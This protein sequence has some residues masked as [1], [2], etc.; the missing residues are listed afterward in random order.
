MLRPGVISCS[1]ALN[2]I[3]FKIRALLISFL[4]GIPFSHS[5][6]AQTNNPTLSIS[7]SNGISTVYWPLTSYFDILQTATTLSPSATWTNLATGEQI[8]SLKTF[9]PLTIGGYATYASNIV[10]DKITF[11]LSSPDTQRFFRLRTPLLIPACCFAIFYDGLLEFSQSPP[12]IINGRVHANGGIFV[13]TSSTT[14][15]IF[16][17]AV[18]TTS[19]VTAPYMDGLTS[20]WIPGIPSTW[21]TTFDGN[22]GFITNVSSVTIWQYVTNYHFLIDVPPAG[23]DPTSSTGQVRYYNQ[24]QM[25]LIVTNAVSGGLNPTV[26]LKL[27]NSVNGQVPGYDPSPVILYYTNASPSLLS[28]NLPFL[29]LTNTAYDQ[30]E[31]ATNIFAQIDVDKFAH[32]I[33]TNAAVQGK[34]PSSAG[35]YPT[36]LYVADL[37][38]N[39]S[40]QLSS[41]RLVNGAQLPANN[42]LGLTLATMNPLYVQGHYNV[43]TASSAANASAGTNNTAYTV[44]SA[45]ISDALTVLSS[46]WSDAVSFTSTYSQGNANY[47]ATDNNTINAAIITGTMPSTGTNG[48]TFSGGFHNLPRLL[49]NWSS[50]NLWLNTSIIRLWNSQ[51]ATNQFRNPAGFSPLPVNPYYNPPTRHFNFDTN[52]L[53]DSKTPPGAPMFSA[54]L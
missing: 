35:V 45:L 10:G 15:L 50:K 2:D 21:N 38:S 39:T 8:L 11:S 16:N 9:P 30:R 23:E 33:Q 48:S 29:S 27:Q 7:T 24:A 4:V 3:R 1:V 31:Y 42:G 19:Q 53:N 25:V 14:N 6:T 22:P 40:H 34:L 44:P 5:A 51:M 36:I 37:R 52:F 41:V 43:Q 28:S 54:T 26:K 46:H 13:G 32:W 47:T 17:A 20:G 49:E 18:T 12:L